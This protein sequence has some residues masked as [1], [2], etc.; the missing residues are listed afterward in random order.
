MVNHEKKMKILFW[1]ATG[2]FSVAMAFS[3]IVYLTSEEVK[4]NFVQLGFPSYFRVELAVFKMLGVLALLLR[5]PARVKEWAYAG[6]GIT[7]ISAFI[8]HIGH[9]DGIDKIIAPVIFMGILM[10]SYYAR[11]KLVSSSKS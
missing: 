6:F 5:V 4:L 1:G 7:L 10:S 2:V 9:G 11:C 8:T 3:A